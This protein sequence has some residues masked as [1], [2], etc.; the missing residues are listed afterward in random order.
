M[1]DFSFLCWKSLQNIPKHHQCLLL[2]EE[3]SHK[4]SIP[5]LICFFSLFPTK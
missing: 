4:T 5:I 2:P 1:L 3:I